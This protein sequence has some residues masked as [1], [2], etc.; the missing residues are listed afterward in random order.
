MTVTCVPMI[1]AHLPKVLLCCCSEG[2]MTDNGAQNP[3]LSNERTRV[4]V[5][6]GGAWGTAL[7]IHCSRMGHDTLLWALEK[8]V[9]EAINTQ[10]ENT[11]FLK[12]SGRIVCG[13]RR[14]QSPLLLYLAP[15]LPPKV[16][17]VRSAPVYN[18]PGPRVA[19]CLMSAHATSS[20]SHFRQDTSCMHLSQGF[21]LPEN[22][23]ATNDMNEVVSH[24]E[25][26]LMVIPTPFVER[27]IARIK[28]QLREDQVGGKRE[29]F[30]PM[31]GTCQ[32]TAAIVAEKRRPDLFVGVEGCW[33][34]HCGPDRR[35][36]GTVGYICLGHACSTWSA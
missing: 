7:A 27:T 12:A 1:P 26:L 8:E 36:C 22:L 24:A 25:L 15:C 35:S 23:R 14:R 2:N 31:R 16:L 32:G 19:A 17:L 20:V 33:P 3:T 30:N 28:D 13:R 18:S 4:G 29:A 10:H 21:P 11:V 5:I 6:G 9:A 34:V